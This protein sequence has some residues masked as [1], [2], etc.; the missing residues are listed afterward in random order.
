MN[1]VRDPK[2]KVGSWLPYDRPSVRLD[3]SDSPPSSNSCARSSTIANRR[4]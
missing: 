2:H 1:S 3:G 4:I